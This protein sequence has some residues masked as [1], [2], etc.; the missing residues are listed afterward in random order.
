MYIDRHWY[1][2]SVM[3]K[4]NG[5]LLTRQLCVRLRVHYAVKSREDERGREAAGSKM[6]MMII[7]R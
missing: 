3:I 6:I 7:Q 5:G 2:S 1:C 4:F